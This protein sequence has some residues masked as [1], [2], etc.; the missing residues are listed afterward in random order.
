MCWVGEWRCRE[1][2]YNEHRVS[3]LEWEDIFPNERCYP[4]TDDPE[5]SSPWHGWKA[6]IKNKRQWAVSH[7][8]ANNSYDSII[9]S[10][11]LFEMAVTKI[12][13]FTIT[14]RHKYYWSKLGKTFKSSF[15]PKD[16]ADFELESGR[17]WPD[18]MYYV[19]KK[20]KKK[21][22]WHLYFLL[23]SRI[24]CIWMIRAGWNHMNECHPVVFYTDY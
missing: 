18:L 24:S 22:M 12:I 4:M 23:L 20:C 21:K 9:V 13:H 3:S 1:G 5:P 6:P 7:G 2:F 11:F 16:N 15:S 14:F 8:L 17:V 10:A 19:T